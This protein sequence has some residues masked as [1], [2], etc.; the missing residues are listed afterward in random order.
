MFDQLARNGSSTA[1]TPSGTASA[2]AIAMRSLV[3]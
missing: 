1:A 3:R 2:T